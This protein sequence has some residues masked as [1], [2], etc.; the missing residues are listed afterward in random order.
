ML[1]RKL[2]KQDDILKCDQCNTQFNEHDVPKFLPCFMTIC[3]KCEFTIQKNTKSDMEFKCLICLKYHHIPIDGF[4]L[5]E[6]IYALLKSAN[7]SSE[8]YNQQN[9]TDLL[10]SVAKIC[11]NTSPNVRKFL[12]KN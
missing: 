1:N 11:S 5:N 8:E 7:Q 6:R 2:F 12:I 9:K 10:S 4:S 3:S